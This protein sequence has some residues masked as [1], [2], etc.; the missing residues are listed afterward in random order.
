MKALIFSLVLLSS[1]GTMAVIVTSPVLF[2][3]LR[4]ITGIGGTGVFVISFVLALE[5]TTPQ[6]VMLISS[7]MKIGF[8]IGGSLVAI[9][10]YFIR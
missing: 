3:I 7:I 5:N 4:V 9:E 10:A 8:V 2:G 1:S 6:C